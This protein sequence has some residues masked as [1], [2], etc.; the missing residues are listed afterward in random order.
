MTAHWG[1]DPSTQRLAIATAGGHVATQAFPRTDGLA[2][3]SDIYE[4]TKEFVEDLLARWTTPGFVLVEQPSG[5]TINLELTYAVGVII[6]AMQEVLPGVR[7]ETIVSS[8]WKKLA[9]GYGHAPKLDPNTGKVWADREQYAVLKWARTN[10]YQGTSYD[11][12]DAL[13]IAEAARR[14]V[15]LDAR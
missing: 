3:L 13:G 14:M 10:G 9:T 7:F 11:E 5:K 12:A 15:H 8:S 6:A 1:C 2:R 4:S